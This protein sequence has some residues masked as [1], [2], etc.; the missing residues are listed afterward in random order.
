MERS[1]FGDTWWW[2]SWRWAKKNIKVK[3]NDLTLLNR[4][5]LY[6]LWEH[7][8]FWFHNISSSGGGRK[9]KTTS[10]SVASVLDVPLRVQYM[11]II[12]CA[13]AHEA[14]APFQSGQN[15]LKYSTHA[16]HVI[17]YY[18][19]FLHKLCVCVFALFSA[20]SIIEVVTMCLSLYLCQWYICLVTALTHP[21]TH[22]TQFN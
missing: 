19:T 18:T 2:E 10:H 11:I 1:P 6:I 13:F 20:C 7:N 17:G 8:Q 5:A 22:N 12:S 15:N 21:Q 4:C 9:N 14:L 3:Q 16:M